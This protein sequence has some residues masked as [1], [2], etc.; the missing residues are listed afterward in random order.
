MKPPFKFT[1]FSRNAGE[2]TEDLPE[3][4]KQKE[5]EKYNLDNNSP[6]LHMPLPAELYAEIFKYLDVSDILAVRLLCKKY[7]NDEVISQAI[8]QCLSQR[9]Q[10]VFK[11]K[12]PIKEITLTNVLTEYEKKLKGSYCIVSDECKVLYQSLIKENA[13]QYHKNI[14]DILEQN[15][16]IACELQYIKG[17]IHN[18]FTWAVKWHKQALLNK[19]YQRQASLLDENKGAIKNHL[20]KLHWAILC[21]QSM[22]VIQPLLR[23]QLISLDADKAMRQDILPPFSPLMCAVIMNR[24]DVLEQMFSMRSRLDVNCFIKNCE[25][26]AV[27][28]AVIFNQKEMIDFLLTKNGK[29]QELS[30]PGS[31]RIN[32]DFLQHFLEPVENE[33]TVSTKKTQYSA[34]RLA[35]IMN[36]KEIL[37]KFQESIHQKEPATVAA[38]TPRI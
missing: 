34:Y 28:L 35:K 18:F 19:I 21:N 2:Q 24:Q 8:A 25:F 1:F 20:H 36:R 7:A 26:N 37:D 6:A 29:F 31:K 30:Q 22:D 27:M 32:S 4:Q 3:T 14:M 15:P 5:N 23:N 12:I 33:K 10:D 16:E 38:T 11:E 17:E 9:Y 13:A